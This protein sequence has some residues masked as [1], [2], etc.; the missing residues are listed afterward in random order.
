MAC[1]GGIDS[2]LLAT[3]AHRLAPGSTTIAHAVSPAVQSDGTRRVRERASIE[4][5]KLEIVDSGEFEDEEYLR[6]PANRCYHC[7]S[8]LYAS[9]SAIA[10]SSSGTVLSGTNLDDLG[11]YRPGLIAASEAGVRHPFVEARLGKSDIRTVAAQEGLPFA[12]LPASPCLSSRLYTGTRVTAGRLAAIENGENAL[13]AL[14]G[15]RVARCRLREDDVLIEVE[16][17][18]RGRVTP[19]VVDQVAE[20]MRAAHPALGR[21]SL[22]PSAYRP[23]RSFVLARA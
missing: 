8:H 23:G 13:R 16:S 1:S 3:I 10:R 19:A 22:D 12:D 17:A 11:E 9:L 21:V 14:T 6:N 20:V 15:I 7:K 2:L 4:G 18:D 5:W